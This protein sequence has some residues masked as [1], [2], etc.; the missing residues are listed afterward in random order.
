MAPPAVTANRQK[1]SALIELLPVSFLLLTFTVGLLL[2]AYVLFARAW[3]QYQG[4]QALYCAAEGQ[5]PM[6]CRLSLDAQLRNFLPWGLRRTYLAGADGAWKLEVDWSYRNC[7]FHMVKELGPRQ[8]LN[9][10]ALRW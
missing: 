1:G 10:K 5:S 9:A 4:E 6:Q 7:K 3:I 2:A 8:I